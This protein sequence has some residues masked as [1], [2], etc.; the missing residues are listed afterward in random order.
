MRE[1]LIAVVDVETTGLFPWGHDRIVEIA[2]VLTSR[3][4]DIHQEYDTLVNPN[5][6]LGP[7][8]IHRI[9]SAEVLGA[10][11]FS[12]IAGDVLAVLRQASIIAG[13]NVS[14]DRRFLTREYERVGAC[15]PETP[16]LCTCQLLGRLNLAACCHE[17]DISFDDA[18]HRALTDARAAAALVHRLLAD[19]PT[20]LRKFRVASVDWPTIDSLGTQRV[21]RDDAREQLAAP[22]RF[23]ERLLSKIHHD[24]DAEE[25]NVIAY[26][27]LI[28]RVLEDRVIDSNEES[29]LVEAAKEWTLSRSQILQ[30]HRTYLHS[31]AV[32]ALADAVISDAE[33]NDL[34][35]VARL[36]GQDEYELDKILES[37]AAQ[38]SAAMPNGEPHLSDQSVVG[39]EVCFTG[40]LQ[41]RL[42]GQPMTRQVAEALA[43][44]AGLVVRNGVTKK[45]NLLVVADPHTQSGKAK[46]ARGYGT[47]IVADS[48]FWRMIG[49][50][51]D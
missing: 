39:Q 22:P 46:K 1:D 24:M 9:T 5:R 35:Q 36:L 41:S 42:N 43:E 4:G 6:D 12:D 27:T 29:V 50:A 44:K 40:E 19:D 28:D 13:H 15:F 32:T 45:L 21:T 11:Q 20:L 23:L 17:F 33:K 38:L 30:A 31:L 7:T 10:P 47:R 48:V 25:P 2:V 3:D 37:A 14:F 34:H 16:L 8:R 26:L 51:V 49:V 18:P